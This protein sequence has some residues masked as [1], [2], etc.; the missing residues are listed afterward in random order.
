MHTPNP[1][2]ASPLLPVASV[3]AFFKRQNYSVC[4]SV[5]ARAAAAAFQLEL[6]IMSMWHVSVLIYK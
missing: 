4:A 5:C 3:C 6:A 1:I 2:L